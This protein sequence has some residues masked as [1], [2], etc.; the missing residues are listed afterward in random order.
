M[1]VSSTSVELFD[2]AL[3][4]FKETYS[5]THPTAW[6]YVNT[7][8]MPHKER[9]VACYID[10]FPHFGDASTSRVEINHHVIKLYLCVDT[11]HLLTLMKRLGLML[12]NQHV[13]LNATI[14][15]QRVHKAHQFGHNC[16][17]DLI[18]KVFD[19]ALNKLL[20]Q[21]KHAEKGGHEEQP[22]SV[23]FTKSWGLPCHHYIHGCLETETPI[24]LQDIHE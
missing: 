17:K 5:G 8:C 7:T 16:F 21:F 19:F 11:P 20:Q 14:E 2:V 3:G 13:E 10:E 15:K 23:R 1:L 18:Y 22:C 9:F 6:Q 4:V 24:L 12:A